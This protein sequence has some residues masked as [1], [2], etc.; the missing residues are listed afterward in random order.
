MKKQTFTL[1]VLLF[2]LVL[3]FIFSKSFSQPMAGFNAL[4]PVTNE[5]NA[6]R[7]GAGAEWE[8]YS[9]EI[10]IVDG[11]KARNSTKPK[12]P[13]TQP[14]IGLRIGGN[15]A[16]ADMGEK[17]INDIPLVAPETGNANVY[18]SNSLWNTNL[19]S[20]FYFNYL[21]GIIIPYTGAFAGGSM[22]ESEMS[23]HPQDNSAYTNSSVSSSQTLNLGGSAG[24]LIN[25]G[26][27][28]IDAGATYTHAEYQQGDYMDLST[29]NNVGG[30]ADFHVGDSPTDYLTFKLGITGYLDGDGKG[31]GN[32]T[33]GLGHGHSCG[34]IGGGGASHINIHIH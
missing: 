25:V 29:L 18:F 4:V 31:K 1:A 14:K 28:F 19:S 20:K 2:S 33:V 21:K 3:L 27:F 23:I 26:G 6:T 5:S 9:S 34:H 11:P 15:I 13:A 7:I 24:L 16:F 22:F 30:A 12:T 8:V 32:H 10:S 17:H